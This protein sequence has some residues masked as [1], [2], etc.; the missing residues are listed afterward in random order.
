MEQ[1]E[2]HLIPVYKEQFPIDL[3][4]AQLKVFW[5]P[6]E[7]KVEKDIQDV[8]VKF[9]EADKHGVITTL[10]LF[11]LYETH[12]GDEYW[13]SRFRKTFKGAE[14]HRMA[15]TFGMMELSVHAP[16]YNKINEL[17]NTNT[18]EFYLSY[19]DNEYLSARMQHIGKIIDD[20]D[21]LVSLAGF[22]M[23]EGVVLYS[24]FAFLKHYQANGKNSII[25]VGRG[26]NF[27]VRDENLHSIAGAH[28]FKLKK[29]QTELTAEQEI[30]LED[31][32]RD[33]ARTLYLHEEKIID[34]IFSKG[35]ID[36]ITPLQMQKFVKS[37]INMC[38]E[39]LGYTKEYE[40]KDNPIAEWFYD[41]INGYKF[42]DFFAGMGSQYNRDWDESAFVWKVKNKED[43][44]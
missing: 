16:F 44:E 21:D 11:S 22:S 1:L 32:I 28:C 38:L 2:E 14:F 33:C 27:S 20:P 8:L 24:N 4:K 13:L 5:L 19:R 17:L 43:D 3:E 39:N 31:K 15:A 7:I 35:R 37:R 25:N 34:L 30:E 36:G 29:Q 12:A 41:G 10:K 9:P 23:V 18:P 42:N 40:V 6:D 26:L